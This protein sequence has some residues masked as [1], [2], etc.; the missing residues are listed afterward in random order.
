[1]TRQFDAI[2]AEACL[3]W[4]V[5]RQKPFW[6]YAKPFSDVSDLPEVAPPDDLRGFLASRPFGLTSIVLDLHKGFSTRTVR[7]IARR[8]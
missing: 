3:F 1:M 5:F 2:K 8:P 7:V 6:Y 4:E